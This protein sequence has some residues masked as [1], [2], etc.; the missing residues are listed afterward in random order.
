M[1]ITDTKYKCDFCEAE[2]ASYYDEPGWVVLHQPVYITVTKG[3]HDNGSANTS[4]VS[5]DHSAH[6]CS[7][8]CLTTMLTNLRDSE[9]ET[10]V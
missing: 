10:S 7:I 6:F 8:F 4:C 5:F 2:T 1:K 3:R 9:N